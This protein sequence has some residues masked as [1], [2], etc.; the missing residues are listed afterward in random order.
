MGESGQW[1]RGP[2]V[3]PVAAP[4]RPDRAQAGS[5]QRALGSIQQRQP[6]PQARALQARQRGRG[7]STCGCGVL[8]PQAVLLGGRELEKPRAAAA[9]TGLTRAP[10]RVGGDGVVGI[11][12]AGRV[13]AA[14]AQRRRLAGA[15][16]R[17]VGGDAGGAAAHGVGGADCAGGA[18]PALLQV[19]QHR[20]LAREQLRQPRAGQQPRGPAAPAAAEV[21]QH[22][23][24]GRGEG[25][26]LGMGDKRRCFHCLEG[27]EPAGPRALE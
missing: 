26:A 6:G 3:W 5:G 20:H 12:R 23:A 7:R 16:T 15:A 25:S 14:G 2:V 13:R 17:E 18:V 8:G 19:A 22:G 21:F 4:P 27:A 9:L 1:P 11:S 24:C 10:R